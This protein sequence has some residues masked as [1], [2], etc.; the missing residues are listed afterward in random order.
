MG[1]RQTAGPW[2]RACADPPMRAAERRGIGSSFCPHQA[3]ANVTRKRVELRGRERKRNTT[4]SYHATWC[5]DW[6][7]G[8]YY[9]LDGAGANPKG[10]AESA[11]EEVNKAQERGKNKVVRGGS[12][13]SHFSSCS[14]TSRREVRAPRM[15]YHSV[16]FRIV[17]A[18]AVQT[19]EKMSLASQR[20]VR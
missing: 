6:Y 2:E 13:Y 3:T 16:G 1:G 15:G 4:V 17:A 12:W 8:D 7:K 20:G 14:T 10:P 9:K 11:A 18:A 5:L 19:F